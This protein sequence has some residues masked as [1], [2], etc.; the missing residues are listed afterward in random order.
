MKAP[1]AEVLHEIFRTLAW[2]CRLILTL[3]PQ[4]EPL[5]P[6]MLLTS[7]FR[8]EK[9]AA[10]LG[11]LRNESCGYAFANMP[12]MPLDVMGNRQD[13]IICLA[14]FGLIHE[15]TI[16]ATTVVDFTRIHNA[17]KSSSFFSAPDLS[18]NELPREI[19]K[20]LERNLVRI[21]LFLEHILLEAQHYDDALILS[22]QIFQAAQD[23]I[24]EAKANP[25]GLQ[26]DFSLLTML[27]A[28][29]EPN[30]KHMFTVRAIKESFT[31]VAAASDCVSGVMLLLQRYL[32]LDQVAP[33]SY[34]Y[35][36]YDVAGQLPTSPL[37]EI[38]SQFLSCL[39]MKNEY[40]F[41]YMPVH[42]SIGDS[43]HYISIW[44]TRSTVDAPWTLYVY[45]SLTVTLDDTYPTMRL[46]D[47]KARL[48]DMLRDRERVRMPRSIT[49]EHIDACQLCTPIGPYVQTGKHEG[50]P[51]GACGY[52]TMLCAYNLARCLNQ[53]IPTS[54]W[55]EADASRQFK[56]VLLDFQKIL[57]KCAQEELKRLSSELVHPELKPKGY[58]FLTKA[59]HD[60]QKKHLLVD[61]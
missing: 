21:S 34:F 53:G 58:F 16:S 52:F 42:V 57:F 5:I 7:C 12:Y 14:V 27:P 9:L 32:L 48:K 1:V 39:A 30:Y 17:S 41:V 29:V 13:A 61:D 46:N 56:D 28:I 60:Y 26:L 38:R 59:E 40:T 6:L 10:M 33:K 4:H 47:T 55:M 23:K 49:E 51:G 43:G 19:R 22:K 8:S 35:T 2:Y 11:A 45:D 50:I 3:D 31:D 25:R 37:P 18:Q 54:S 20:N 15:M 36:I 44:A 24:D